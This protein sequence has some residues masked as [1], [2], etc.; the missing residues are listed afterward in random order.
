MWNISIQFGNGEMI[1]VIIQ[2]VQQYSE[3][4]LF[5]RIN[6]FYAQ[7]SKKEIKLVDFRIRD[8]AIRQKAV[9]VHGIVGR[10]WS[11]HEME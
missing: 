6:L 2:K 9:A 4:F 3:K 11:F 10:I 7:R 1:K 5:I 8:V